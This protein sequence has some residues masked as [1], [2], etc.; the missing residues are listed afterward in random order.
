MSYFFYIIPV[1]GIV[2]AY[3]Y[4]FHRRGQIKNAGGADAYSR[5]RLNKLFQLTEGESVTAAWI[6]VTIPKKNRRNKMVEAL[7]FLMIFIAGFRIRVVGRELRVVCTTE[8]RVLILDKEDG[9]IQAFGPIRRPR[10]VS[11]G[12]KGTK[13]PRRTSWGW[14]DG[15]IVRL[16]ISGIEP[17]EIDILASAVPVLAGWSRGGDV[18]RLTGPYPLPETV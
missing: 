2:F 14:D 3:V 1:L 13:H 6:A 8:N 16:E 4:Y 7:G 17:T 10:F 15:A 5:D 18:S 9:Y 11:T 12:K